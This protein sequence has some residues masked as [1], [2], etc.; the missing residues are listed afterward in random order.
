MQ[1]NGTRRPSRHRQ[2]N[3]RPGQNGDRGRSSA[4]RGSG[5][6]GG[7]GHANAKR[8]YERYMALA[9]A[10]ALTGDHVETENFY[11]HAEHY[12]RVLKE[13]SAD[14]NS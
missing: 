1:N 4:S 11:Q 14:D 13:H 12:F 6:N 9:R 10:S 8:Q 2:D 7:N 5:G 3:R